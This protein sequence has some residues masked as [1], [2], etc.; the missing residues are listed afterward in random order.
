MDILVKIF[1]AKNGDCFLINILDYNML[2]DG[3]YVNTYNDYLKKEFDNLIN[4]SLNHLIVTHIDCDHISGIIKL[5]SENMDNSIVKI[6]NVWHNSLRHLSDLNSGDMIDIKGNPLST[7]NANFT[8]KEENFDKEKEISAVQGSTLASLLSKK[9]YNW[10]KEFDENAVSIDNRL[11]IQLTEDI[12]LKLLSPNN[13]KL[14]ELEKSWK[15][16]LYKKGY[17]TNADLNDFNEDLFE[18]I[19]S[20]QKE[21]KLIK[22][23]NISHADINIQ[24]ILKSM[25][26]EDTAPANGSS[27]SFILEYENKKL[28]FLAD[29]HPSVI[30]KSLHL[31]YENDDFPIFFDMIKLS[32]HG[33]NGNTSP[34]LL[35]LID[36]DK[37]IFSTNGKPFQHPDIET[38]ARIVNRKAKKTRELFFNYP[39]EIVKHLRNNVLMERYNFKITTAEENEALSIEF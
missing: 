31:H 38:I 7:L 13:E 8:L 6:Q 16:E 24:E 26:F 12:T 5:I 14:H 9:E 4:R 20:K 25:F 3:G 28:L 32:H 21:K 33:S 36:S 23:K 17:S 11:E 15:K 2:I 22:R 39:L 34:E 1:P 37:Y 10:N 27:I 18:A 19:I 30:Q 29:S 35:E